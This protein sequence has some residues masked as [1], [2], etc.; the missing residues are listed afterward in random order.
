MRHLMKR[1]KIGGI[2]YEIF[3][4]FTSF[5][6]G[7]IEDKDDMLLTNVPYSKIEEKIKELKREAKEHVA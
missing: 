6:M 5:S 7:S 4:V 2:T 1:I 3:S